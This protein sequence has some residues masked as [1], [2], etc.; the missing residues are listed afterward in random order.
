MWRNQDVPAKYFPVALHHRG[1]SK[2]ISHYNLLAFNRLPARP[3]SGQ[4]NL[5]V[6]Q[7]RT[8]NSSVTRD[9]LLSLI[10][11][12]IALSKHYSHLFNREKFGFNRGIHKINSYAP[13]PPFFVLH[14]RTPKTTTYIPI[15]FSTKRI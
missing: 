13:Q 4:K 5:S 7:N 3:K 2:P 9:F 1:V 14:S 6:K 8:C 10:N 12:L 11:P 15:N